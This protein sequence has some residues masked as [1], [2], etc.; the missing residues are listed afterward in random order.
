MTVTRRILGIDPGSRVTGFGI[1]EHTTR[2]QLFCLT[3]GCVRLTAEDM[4]SRLAHLFAHLQDIVKHFK[5]TELAIERVFVQK[6]AQSALKLGQAR[7]VAIAAVM[8]TQIPVFE[9]AP[10]E[11]KLAIVGKG[12]AEKPQIQHMVQILLS[13]TTKPQADAADALAV[14]L[15]HHHRMGS[16]VELAGKTRRAKRSREWVGYDRTTTR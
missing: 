16:P 6:N 3:G 10:R 5:P 13:L 7:G 11:I 4:P 15:C 8:S 12:S 2:G 14:A 1:I 9:Y